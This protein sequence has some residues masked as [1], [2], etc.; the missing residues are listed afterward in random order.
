MCS[1]GMHI[2]SDWLNE[3]SVSQEISLAGFIVLKTPFMENQGD[4]ELELKL[5]FTTAIETG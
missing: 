4:N 5:H 1:C 3:L 2:P